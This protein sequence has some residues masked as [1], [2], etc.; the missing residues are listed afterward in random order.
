MRRTALRRTAKPCRPGCR[1][2][3]Q[4]FAK[5]HRPTGRGA[6]P[7]AEVTETRR[8]SAPGRAGISR[9]PIAQGRPGV[10][11]PTCFPPAHLRVQILRAAGHGCQPAPGLPCALFT[12]EGQ[13][14]QQTSG[15]SCRENAASCADNGNDRKFSPRRRRLYQRRAAIAVSSSLTP[16]PRSA[17]PMAAR[18][19]RWSA[20]K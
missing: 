11:R 13:G 14:E 7:F 16:G 9:Q 5:M 10:F 17:T 19:G 6:S 8:N 1:C 3:S 2:Y 15:A 20:V 12:E 4:A 18:A